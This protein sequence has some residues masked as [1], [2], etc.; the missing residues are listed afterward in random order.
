MKLKRILTIATLLSGVAGV[1][2]VAHATEGWYGR[3]DVGYSVDGYI[4]FNNGADYGLED[5]WMGAIGAGYAFA[6]GLRVEG[7]LSYRTNALDTYPA[8][9]TATSAMGNLYYD[10][11]RGGR[12]EPYVG[13]G[14]G[15][16]DLEFDGT[17][18]SIDVGAAWQALAGVAI[19]LTDRLDLDI[20]YRYFQG[21]ELEW[22]FGGGGGDFDYDHQAVT[23]GLRYQFSAPAAAA[24]VAAPPPAPPPTPPQPQATTCPQSEF[25]VYFEWDRSALNQ[26]ALETIDAAVNAARACN[27]A[28]IVVVGHTD[29]SG[30]PQYNQGLSERRAGVVREALVARGIADGSITTAARGETELAQQTRDGVREPLNRRTAVTISFR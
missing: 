14:I 19:G 13:V 17:P 4:D 18:E 24:P 3:A 15:V 21:I 23:L 16:T 8:D 26:A 5:D 27:I 10:F 12:F 2:G 6:G 22:E 20:G 29:T 28:N 7:E 9:I 30:S 11:N 1:T 25:V